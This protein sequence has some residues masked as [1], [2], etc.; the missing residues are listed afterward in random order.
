VGGGRITSLG[1]R[2][3][4]SLSRRLCFWLLKILPAFHREQTAHPATAIRKDVVLFFIL[5][6]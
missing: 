6:V 1:G 5:W 4:V 3:T 2:P